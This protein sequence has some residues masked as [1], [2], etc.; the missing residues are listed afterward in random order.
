[1]IILIIGPS[2]MSVN[3]NDNVSSKIPKS[4]EN[5]LISFPVGVVSK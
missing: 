5:L 3:T 2:I 4:L 1:M